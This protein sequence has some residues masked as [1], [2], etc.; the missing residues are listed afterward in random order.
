MDRTNYVL[1]Q[2]KSVTPHV[3]NVNKKVLNDISDQA[4]D[5]VSYA[6]KKAFC[7]LYTEMQRTG[8]IKRDDSWEKFV[9][10]NKIGLDNHL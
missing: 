9:N 7:G 2:L 5:K 1:K 4:E 3:T 10:P 8:K 6:Y